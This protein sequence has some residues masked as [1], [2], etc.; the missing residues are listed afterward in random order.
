MM[1]GKLHLANDVKVALGDQEDHVTH[2]HGVSPDI[3][4]EGCVLLNLS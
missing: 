1:H 4:E 3:L 2:V